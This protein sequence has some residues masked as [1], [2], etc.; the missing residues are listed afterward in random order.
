MQLFIESIR[1]YLYSLSGHSLILF[2]LFVG[3]IIAVL[4]LAAGK[5]LK[6]FL[7]TVGRKLISFTKTEID[8]KIL[9]ILLGRIIA[10]SGIAGIYFAVQ[11]I[12]N[13]ISP[14][15]T[16]AVAVLNYSNHAIYIATILVLTSLAIRTTKMLTVHLL[17]NAPQQYEQVNKTL[18]PLVNRI[19]S[20][21]LVLFALALSLDHFGQNITSIL[22]I[23]GAGSLAIGLAAQE[24]ISN[25]ISGF[26]IML[27]RPFRIG[28]R[29]KIPTGEIGNIY[30]IGLRSTKILDFDNNLIIVPNNELIKTRMVNFDYPHGE[31]R[32]VVDVAAAYGTDVAK[33]KALLTQLAL[34][35]P[36]VLKKPVPEVFL[37]SF[38]D[39]ALNFQLVC[40]VRSFQ[41]RFGTA[42]S[43]RVQIYETFLKEKI[44]IP[45]PQREIQLRYSKKKL[46]TSSQ[47]K[48]LQR[49]RRSING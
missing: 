30:E 40:R 11:E 9:D 44:E 23:L 32:V 19:L 46:E 2:H 38:G 6:L 42:E 37:T 1:E 39:S 28:D 21:A 7:S 3:I 8:D 49:T 45:F 36:A 47:R 48:N 24:T 33:V 16:A 31:I 27:D 41:E 10:L 35:H 43:L 15:N 5:L 18:A 20:I 13:G 34:Q 17:E 29:I 26:I 22:T 12:A 4:C 14:E 25:M